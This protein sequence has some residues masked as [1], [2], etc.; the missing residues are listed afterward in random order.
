M[1]LV[2]RFVRRLIGT[3][4]AL[5]LAT[6][7]LVPLTLALALTPGS[8]SAHAAVG[9]VRLAHLS[10]DTPAVDVYLY[11]FGGSTPKLVL[12][13]VPYG[14]VSPYERLAVG[15]YTVAMRP[16]GAAASTPPVLSA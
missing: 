3:G 15:Q 7:A 9:H 6:A 2:A 10:P 12:K 8:A 11:P 5:L 16:A 14:G 4:T 13:A 1:L